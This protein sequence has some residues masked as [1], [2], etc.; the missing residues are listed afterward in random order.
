MQ[1][2]VFFKG[3][4]IGLSLSSFLWGGIF[5]SVKKLIPASDISMESTPHPFSSVA[6]D[7]SEEL[8]KTPKWKSIAMN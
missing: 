7:W 6:F 5:F 4:I 3:L 8:S 2:L 1:K